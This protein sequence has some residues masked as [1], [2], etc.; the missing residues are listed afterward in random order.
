M[1]LRSRNVVSVSR[2]SRARNSRSRLFSE[3]GGAT[4]MRPRCDRARMIRVSLP[5]WFDLEMWNR[6]R[7]RFRRA[8][9]GDT[10]ARLG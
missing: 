10:G 1:W 2:P 3:P 7:K 6:P 9:P 8:R 5:C 4:T